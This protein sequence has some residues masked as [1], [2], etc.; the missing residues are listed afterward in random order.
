MRHV[1]SFTISETTKI[2]NLITVTNQGTHYSARQAHSP[3]Q[4]L[5]PGALQFDC[6][7]FHL[8]HSLIRPAHDGYLHFLLQYR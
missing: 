2:K 1:L 8:W 5:L 7:I 6:E 3:A 4:S